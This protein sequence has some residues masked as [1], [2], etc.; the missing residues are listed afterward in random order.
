MGRVTW[1]ALEIQLSKTFVCPSECL[2]PLSIQSE[3]VRSFVPWLMGLVCR[4]PQSDCLRKD[5]LQG[6]LLWLLAHVSSQLPPLASQQP[7]VPGQVFYKFFQALHA[8]HTGCLPSWPS[9]STLCLNALA[10]SAL[11]PAGS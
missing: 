8:S 4:W 1:K 10:C 2:F 6:N 5:S 11:S 3:I 9:V 7:S